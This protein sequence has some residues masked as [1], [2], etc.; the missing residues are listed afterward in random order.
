MRGARG[1]TKPI[2]DVRVVP[3]RSAKTQRQWVR[4]RYAEMIEQ[5]RRAG[6]HEKAEQLL[7]EL[8]AK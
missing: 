1:K 4:E 8:E 2:T 3:K 6:D 7:R 5:A